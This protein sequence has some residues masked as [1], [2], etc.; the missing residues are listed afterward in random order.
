MPLIVYA[1][2]ISPYY[3]SITKNQIYL[4]AWYGMQAGHLIAYSIPA[5]IWPFIYVR[6]YTFIRAFWAYTWT[7]FTQILGLVT[8]AYTVVAFLASS[9]KYNKISDRDDNGE[10]RLQITDIWCTE[11]LYLFT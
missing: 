6:D 5:I 3:G 9:Y 4:Y 7:Y 10:L 11:V 1:W 2:L 8:F